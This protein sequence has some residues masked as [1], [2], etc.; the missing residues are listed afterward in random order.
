MKHIKLHKII[1]IVVSLLW[2][3]FQLFYIKMNKYDIWISDPGL[4]MYLAT[5][6]VKH[7][8]MYPDWTNYHDSYIFNPGWVNFIILWIKLFSNAR[9]LP[10]FNAFINLGILLLIYKISFKLFN[11]E[12]IAQIATYMFMLLPSF[13]TIASHTYSEPLFT[14]LTLMIL[15]LVITFKHKESY[16]IILLLGIFTAIAMW[17]RPI[18][19][20]YLFACIFLL[21]KDNKWKSTLSYIGIYVST[22][23]IISIATHRNFPDY[24]YK[25]TTGGVNLVMGNNNMA[26][27][28][29]C[30]QAISDSSGLGFLPD[31]YSSNLRP[32][33]KI[34]TAEHKEYGQA[35]SDN[36]TYREI[37]SIWTKRALIWISHNPR[38]YLELSVN[39]LFSL[40]EIAPTFLYS[41]GA[42][43]RENAKIPNMI[44]PLVKFSST[45]YFYFLVI[46]SLVS[47][48]FLSWHKYTLMFISIP[49]V[50]TTLITSLIISSARYN[51]IMHPLIAITAAYSFYMLLKTCIQY[52]LHSDI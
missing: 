40:Y 25:A 4:Y 51:I 50:I 3:V 27:G 49:L 42:E 39:R 48:I 44:W 10:Y 19:Y 46:L 35:F 6:C 14:L 16:I 9:Y 13:P 37:D 31:M 5:E 1:L 43:C 29:Y 52:S 8:T 24:I 18:V 11:K 38:R 21:L 23:F 33:Y 47:I 15:Y 17:V 28:K 41:Y 20:A 2:F 34:Y 36:Y 26:N 12:L 45:Y 7:N 32:V 30:A 22:C